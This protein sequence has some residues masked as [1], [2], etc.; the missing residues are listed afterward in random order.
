M[1]CIIPSESAFRNFQ[2]LRM[3]ARRLEHLAGLGLPIAGRDVLEVG[4]G[5]GDL[6]SFFL[7]HGCSVTAIEPRPANRACFASQYGE[8]A[9]WPEGRLRVLPG[10]AGR[11]AH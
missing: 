10:D 2:Y 3:N 5:I 11:L 1:D 7:D 6:T 8:A 4:A 9:S